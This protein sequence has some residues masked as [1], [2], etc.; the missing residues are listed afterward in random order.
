MATIPASDAAL[1]HYLILAPFGAGIL[2]YDG[3]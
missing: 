1:F 3:T 2:D